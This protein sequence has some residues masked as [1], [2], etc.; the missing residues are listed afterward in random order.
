MNYPVNPEPTTEVSGSARFFQALR[1]GPAAL[2]DPD[3]LLNLIRSVHADALLCT[4]MPSA[5]TVKLLIKNKILVYASPTLP[6]CHPPIPR[7]LF[8]TAEA[9]GAAMLR[10]YQ[11]ALEQELPGV[12]I[13]DAETLLEDDSGYLRWHVACCYRRV[14]AAA[15]EVPV[16]AWDPHIVIPVHCAQ[17]PVPLSELDIQWELLDGSKVVGRGR[18][19]GSDETSEVSLH[20]RG[21]VHPDNWTVEPRIRLHFH[22]LSSPNPRPAETAASP[23]NDVLVLRRSPLVPQPGGATQQAPPIQLSGVG[24]EMSRIEVGLRMEA[25]VEC[26]LRPLPR[27]ANWPRSARVEV[28]LENRTLLPQDIEIRLTLHPQQGPARS[29][30]T[31][32]ISLPAAGVTVRSVE[33]PASILGV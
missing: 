6:Y 21:A 2:A 25:P 31:E 7:S 16:A 8:S 22:L 15:T 5:S 28:R 24:P 9:W 11:D 18:A 20:L 27:V 17:S 14:R 10:A 12:C 4:T 29:V 26:S 32:S 13:A 23:G 30:L 19:Q 3:R 1:A 33:L